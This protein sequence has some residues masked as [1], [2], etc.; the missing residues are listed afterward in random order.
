MSNLFSPKTRLKG[1]YCPIPPFFT[2]PSKGDWWTPLL[3]AFFIRDGI[4]P[5]LVD[6]RRATFKLSPIII[7]IN[8]FFQPVIDSESAARYCDDYQEN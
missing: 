1:G 8:R 4:V 7:S 6:K 5:L 2:C 3:F